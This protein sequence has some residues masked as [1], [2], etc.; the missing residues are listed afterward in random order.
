MADL[1][2]LTRDYLAAQD[3]SSLRRIAEGM[4]N[5]SAALNDYRNRAVDD[6]IQN[7]IVLN[8]VFEYTHAAHAAAQEAQQREPDNI[9]DALERLATLAVVERYSR[10]CSFVDDLRQFIGKAV[11]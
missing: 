4:V 9:A 1:S 7:R 3:M 8:E 6:S 10:D 5:A 11:A 2:Y